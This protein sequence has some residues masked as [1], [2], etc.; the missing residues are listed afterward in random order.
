MCADSRASRD[1]C[2]VN[3]NNSRHRTTEQRHSQWSEA[4]QT[5]AAVVTFL[6]EVNFILITH[7]WFLLFRD[8][9]LTMSSSR[10]TKRK[11]SK[12]GPTTSSTR[13]QRAV[14][15]NPAQD[16]APAQADKNLSQ[17]A[18]IT[19]ATKM[20]GNKAAVP[21]EAITDSPSSQLPK[22]SKEKK[23]TNNAN[24]KTESSSEKVT[25][26]SKPRDG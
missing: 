14:A 16:D 2:A 22:Q 17:Q 4:L 8:N 21:T 19:T 11:R 26:A 6:G 18:T 15:P 13:N 10:N 3:N 5:T 25:A 24:E 12:A 23:G 7:T 1:F 9:S 20:D